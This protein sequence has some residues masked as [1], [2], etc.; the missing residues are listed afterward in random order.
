M[1]GNWKCSFD[2][3]FT[4]TSLNTSNW[5][6]Q[7]TADSG[8]ATGSASAAACYVNS[9]NTISVSGGY[10]HLTVLKTAAPFTCNSP[11]G[12]FTTQYTAGMVSTYGLFDQAYGAFEVN[13]ELPQT[14]I[15]GIQETFWLYPQNLTYG[16]WPGSG[17]IDFAEF[18]SEYANN[19]IPY[20][21]YN[22]ASSDPNVT[23]YNCTI[24]PTGFNTYGMQ[25]S[26]GSLTVYYNG[27]VCLVDHPNLA[28]PLSGN[29]PFDQPFFIA[30]TQALGSNT[31]AFE[32]GTTPLPATTLVKYV[33]AWT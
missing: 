23:A 12:S 25:W 17:E 28:A 6:P 24:N 19:D 8:Y 14:T 4:G 11:G 32:S 29:E 9:P 33:R 15:K 21:H 13:A 31:N 27:K 16:A 10:L 18:Y 5:I 30:L 7:L 1:P 3:E 26:P 20:I 2:D 22:G